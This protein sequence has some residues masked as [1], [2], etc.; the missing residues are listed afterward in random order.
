V[1]YRPRSAVAIDKRDR[2]AGLTVEVLAELADAK[3]SSDDIA[4]EDP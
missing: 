3:R 1:Q 2:Y 4:S